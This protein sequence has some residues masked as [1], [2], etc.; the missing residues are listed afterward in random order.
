MFP[1]SSS[2]N[3]AL[4]ARLISWVSRASVSMTVT[5]SVSGARFSRV[6]FPSASLSSAMSMPGGRG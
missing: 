5:S 1:S 6:I 4:S 3:A 2:V